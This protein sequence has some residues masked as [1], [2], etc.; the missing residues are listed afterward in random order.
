MGEVVFF[1][2]FPGFLG[3]RIATDVL[4]D[5]AVDEVVLVVQDHFRKAAE[6][7]LERLDEPSRKKARLVA[8]DITARGCGLD[9]AEG[10]K[11]RERVTHAYHLAA[12]Y[13]LALSREVGF[14]VNVEGTRNVLDL[15]EG[16]PRFERLAYVSTCA[17]S[18]THQGVFSEDDFDVR[19]GFKNFYEETKY[20]AEAE[21]RGRWG[22]LPTVIF[23]PSV[24]VGDSRT[25]EAEKIDGPYYAFLMIERGLTVVAA[26]SNARFHVVPVNFVTDGIKTLFKNPGS[27]GRVFHLV[28][29]AP[30]TFNEFFDVSS[31]ALGKRRPFLRLPAPWFGPVFRF[32]GV[33]RVSGIPAQSF[34]YSVTQVDWVCPRT[35][36]ALEGTGLRCPRF[37]EY[38]PALARYFK[39]KLL[40]T[41]PK[42]G[43]W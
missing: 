8:G 36:R 37:P 39:D 30:L 23:R 43:R 13:N 22:R 1:T 6:Q 26:Y 17:I 35:L 12:A 3:K 27:A 41:L 4:A 38:A 32:P 9:R 42:A 15:L 29:P 14:K 19:Q 7:A 31:D 40:P 16:A 10:E 34:D 5:P 33:A 20:L 2:G 28:D 21:V 24:V 25:G 11:L 18:G